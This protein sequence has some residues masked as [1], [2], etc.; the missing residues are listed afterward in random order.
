[1][2]T[3]DTSAPA[4]VL[5]VHDH[6]GLGAVRSLGRLGV[7][8]H[9]TFLR[10]RDAARSSRY[11]RASHTW[12]LDHRP[13]DE[14]VEFLLGVGRRLGRPAVLLPSEDHSAIFIAE[15]ADRLREC[16]LVPDQPPHLTRDVAD[17]RRLHE[18][19]V[20]TGTPTPSS[21]VPATVGEVEAFAAGARYPVVAK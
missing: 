4:V 12:D 17:K 6:G 2:T 3:F 21:S 9:G 1:M 19:C 5:S 14:S 10:D 18:L 13:A 7:E 20:E 8:V 15:Q 16:F 11:L